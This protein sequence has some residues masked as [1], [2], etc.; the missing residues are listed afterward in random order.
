MAHEQATFNFLFMALL[1]LAC[2]RI[3]YRRS[4]CRIGPPKSI[5]CDIFQHVVLSRDSRVDEISS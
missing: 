5:F 2:I 1:R 3:L 4:Q